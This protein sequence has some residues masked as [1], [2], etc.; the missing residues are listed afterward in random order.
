M[1]IYAMTATFGKL[2]H[3][4]LVLKPGLNIITAPNEW[5]KST[6]CAFLINM[7]YGMDTRA[8]S[9]KA[10]LADKERYAPW[11]GSPMSGR[12]DLCWEGRDI[13]IERWTKGRTP[14]GEFRAYE[15]DSGYAVPE[16]T[17]GNCGEILLGVERSVFQ[18]SGFLRLADLPV[19]QDESLR[20]RLNALVTTGDESG[21]AEL[22]AQ[23]LKALK[24][25]IRHNRTGLLPQA[26]AELVRLEEELEELDALAAAEEKCRTRLAEV[27]ARIRDL[28][29]HL[30]ALH[31]AASMEE[32]DRVAQSERNLQAAQTRLDEAQ[33][34]CS[35][36][37]SRE[38]AMRN[39]E[40]LSAIQQQAGALEM[41]SRLGLQE[42]EAP[43]PPACF[44]GMTPENMDLCLSADADLHK[45]MTRLARKPKLWCLL[46]GAA[47]LAAGLWYRL[48][49]EGSALWCIPGG[50]AL[51]LGILWLIL[52]LDRRNH[53]RAALHTLFLR[54]GSSSPKDWYQMAGEYR[55]SLDAYEHARQ[56]YQAVH[57]GLEAQATA[58][59][60]KLLNLTGG[61]SL[62]SVQQ[63]WQGILA[64]WN[65][66]A[67][68][69]RDA[70]Q[71]AGSARLIAS[72]AKP[73]PAP[74]RPDTLIYT[75]AETLRILSDA[76]QEQQELQRRLGL[77]Q[78][79]MEALGHRDILL[80]KQR[81]LTERV[82]KLRDHYAA[83][84]YAQA[85]LAEAAA[86]LQ[87]R[88]APK[89]SA[90]AQ[91]LFSRLT[92]GK[93][94]RFSLSEDLSVNAGASGED[95]LRTAQWRSDGTAD[96]LYLALRLAVACEL[97]PDAPLILDDALVRFDDKR[98][99]TALDILR[100]EAESK[101]VILFTCQTREQNL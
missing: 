1:K 101:Q 82:R 85:A 93:Y 12:I 63:R 27:Q 32:A 56:D 53:A 3:E 7:L 64:A 6:W 59:Q 73:I 54:Y 15:T 47:L 14:M 96:Q 62:H 13:T 55:Q 68:A 74:S 22:L 19:T 52:A 9:T 44:Q 20:R 89:I 45:K 61:Q 51:V 26:E 2:E 41:E 76:S 16:L 10:A 71:A 25:K 46:P 5:G 98:L 95:V 50:I 29:N 49:M 31:Y 38:E 39:L 8:K 99:K 11:S 97:T 88:F 87:R 57:D 77:H 30:D 33:A 92:E 78:G 91:S 80:E 24:N 37:P 84:E 83:L 67:D 100:E 21:S 75:E 28:N 17:A 35:G 23:Q 72:M 42:P 66:L 48:A 79:R 69:R 34:R 94:D 90:R 40:A 36:L 81:N 58:L 60:A 43:V 86:E 4:T 65:E 18:R 70:A